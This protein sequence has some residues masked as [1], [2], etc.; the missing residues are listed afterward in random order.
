MFLRFGKAMAVSTCRATTMAAR[1]KDRTNDFRAA[2]ELQIS[3]QLAA[4]DSAGTSARR[5][6]LNGADSSAAGTSTSGAQ[7]E[8]S[9]GP[10]AA[11]AEFARRAGAI[12]R[13]IG[14]TTAK[15]EKL[16]QCEFLEEH[17]TDTS[18]VFKD[19]HTHATSL[20]KRTDADCALVANYSGQAQVAIR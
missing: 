8:P 6:L 5:P 13:E 4:D 12:G 16:A 20:V 9:T 2:V 18:N 15:L 7:A 11:R 17:N 3:R 19:V 10:K 14:Q 1:F